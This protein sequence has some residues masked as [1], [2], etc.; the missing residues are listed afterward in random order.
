MSY[1]CWVDVIYLTFI[2]Q[3]FLIAILDILCS[4]LLNLKVKITKGEHKEIFCDPSKLFT[5]ISWPIN[6][7][8]KFFMTP[9]KTL[10]SPS[11]ILIVSSLSK[12]WF[13]GNNAFMQVDLV[14]MNVFV[15]LTSILL[16]SFLIFNLCFKQYV[17]VYFFIWRRFFNHTNKQIKWGYLIIFNVSNTVDS[18]KR[19]L[20]FLG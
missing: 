6:I 11:Y 4:D 2:Y 14:F 17:Y 16:L 15:L 7:S 18:C 9:T 12:P 5:N 13:L 3:I 19:F 1:T 8:L 10:W 20:H